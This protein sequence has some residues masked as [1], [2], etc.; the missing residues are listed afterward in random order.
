MSID[1]AALERTMK[2]LLQLVDETGVVSANDLLLQL[3]VMVNSALTVLAVDSVGLMLLDEEDKPRVATATDA[4]AGLLEDLQTELGEGP[5]METLRT[6]KTIAVDDLATSG[7]YPRLSRSL[8]GSQIAAVLSSPIRV[9]DTIAGNFNAALSRPHDWTE[10]QIKA[11]DA[12]ANLIGMALR[13]SARAAK[14]DDAVRRLTE[15]WTRS[16]GPESLGETP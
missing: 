2:P 15:Q 12:Y 16:S 6:G 4:A 5:G 1:P 8:A 13:V 7:R 10:A 14:A 3:E 9:D 11:N